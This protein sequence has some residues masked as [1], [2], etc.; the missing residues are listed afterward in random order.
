[1]QR[2]RNYGKVVAGVLMLSCAQFAAAQS[3][4]KDSATVGGVEGIAKNI[5]YPDMAVKCRVEGRVVVEARINEHGT[6]TDAKIIQGIGFGCDEEAL[7]AVKANRYSVPLIDGK[8]NEVKV[9][10]PV[11]FK[12]RLKDI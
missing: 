2:L 3:G 1:M 12:L 6:C 9:M 4:M 5:S 7:R 8:R 11:R 10:I